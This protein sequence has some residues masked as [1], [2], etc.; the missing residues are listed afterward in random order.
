VVLAVQGQGQL[1]STVGCSFPK[2]ALD[3]RCLQARGGRVNVDEEGEPVT[4][5]S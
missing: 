5:H 1:V 3:T 2:F 4:P